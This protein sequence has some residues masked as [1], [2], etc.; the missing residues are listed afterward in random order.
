MRSLSV[1]SV[2]LLLALFSGS[3]GVLAHHAGGVEIGDLETGSVVGQPFKE[4]PVDAELYALEIGG[5]LKTWYAPVT[6]LDLKSRPGR[7]VVIKLTN[8]SSGDMG[9]LM[10]ADGAFEAPT[11]MKA[12][13]VLKPG[14]SKYVGVPLSDLLYATQGST[15]VYRDHLHAGS[16]GGKLL[17]I[18]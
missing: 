1:I 10:T 8:K 9:F 17:I 11:V 15:F 5:G 2:L 6:V 4:L 7:P 14:E 18:R 3:S 12:Q 13:V 16:I